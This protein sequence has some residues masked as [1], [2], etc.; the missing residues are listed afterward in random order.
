MDTNIQLMILVFP[1]LSV[2]VVSRMAGVSSD[3]D[4]PRSAPISVDVPQGSR[5]VL[6]CVLLCTL[7]LYSAVPIPHSDVTSPDALHHSGL[8]SP[9]DIGVDLEPL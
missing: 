3:P 5:E 6:L 8:E 2:S 9:L 4:V 1:E 7:Q